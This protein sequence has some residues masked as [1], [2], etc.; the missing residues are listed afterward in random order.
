MNNTVLKS[1][2][3]D[4]VLY[5]TLNHPSTNT[6]TLDI[7]SQFEQIFSDFD[8]VSDAMPRLIIIRSALHN[9]FS[10]GVDPKSFLA[11][12]M[13]GRR[14]IFQ[15]LGKMVYAMQRTGIPVL[16]VVNGPAFAG[17]AVLA[18]LADF[19]FVH[20]SK[21]VIAFSEP[22]VNL[23]IPGFLQRLISRKMHG[24][25]A[26]KAWLMGKNFTAN[27][28]IHLGAISESYESE[29]DLQVKLDSYIS[30]VKR[31]NGKVL[32]YSLLESKQE[33]HDEFQF[34]QDRFDKFAE[35]LTDEYLGAALKHLKGD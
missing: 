33:L 12:D 8:L 6:L 26:L 19:V 22:K 13:D 16:S 30:K 27:Q 17:G 34:F 24:D 32:R 23:P 2:I 29:E 1:E 31:L 25:A 15:T 11:S 5:L 7:M 28:L 4:Q 14:E 21:G 10:Y 3:K 9:C 20:E 18:L 35:F